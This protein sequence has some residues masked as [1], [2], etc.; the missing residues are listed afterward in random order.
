[1]GSSRASREVRYA[2]Q[3]KT[4]RKPNC[5]TK[6]KPPEGGLSVTLIDCGSDQ[7]KCRSRIASTIRRETDP[8]E[9]EEHH[10]PR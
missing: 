7:A 2:P 9:P 6:E 10:G 8:D 4:H 1:M 3:T 5:R